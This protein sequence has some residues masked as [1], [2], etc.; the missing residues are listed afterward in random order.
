MQENDI[1]QLLTIL[2][3]NY[4]AAYRNMSA[5]DRRALV[6]L[7]MDAFGGLDVAIA[8]QALRNYIKANQYPPTIAGLQEQ[9]DLLMNKDNTDELWRLLMRA[10]RSCGRDAKGEFEKLP[11]EC[12]AFMGSAADLRALGNTDLPTVNTVT[13]GQFYSRVK[14]MKAQKRAQEQ[15]QDD[16]RWVLAEALRIRA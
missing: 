13:R 6:K 5:E 12:K 9:I 10:I 16:I 8:G 7:W 1:K 15:L 14:T 3:L 11:E 2:K 4:P